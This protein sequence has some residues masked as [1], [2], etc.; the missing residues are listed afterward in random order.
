MIN[1]EKNDATEL[2]VSSFVR[3]YIMITITGANNAGR[4]IS[5]AYTVSKIEERPVRIS[6][7][8]GLSPVVA[9]RI[10]LKASCSNSKISSES[11]RGSIHLAYIVVSS[12]TLCWSPSKWGIKTTNTDIA[13]KDVTKI[14]L[15]FLFVLSFGRSKRS[16]RWNIIVL[17]PNRNN[18]ECLL[19]D[20]PY[21]NRKDKQYHYKR[22]K[23]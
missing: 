1:E 4:I 11:F 21:E 6:S 12:A 10:S 5:N 23:S 22:S 9:P 2:S 8:R 19:E 13:M 20:Y 14:I 18:R 7:V 16:L 17:N 3:K 15:V